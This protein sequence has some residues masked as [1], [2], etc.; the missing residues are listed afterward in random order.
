MNLYIFNET[1]KGAVY[2]IGTYIQELSTTLKSKDINICIINLNSNRAQVQIEEIK[3]IKYW[4]FPE[5]IKQTLGSK[6]QWDLYHRNIVYL[7][8]LGIPDKT[9]LIFHL[10]YNLK[11]EF[12]KELKKVFDCRIVLTVHYFDWCFKLFGN[13]TLLRQLLESEQDILNSHEIAEVKEIFQKERETFKLVDHIICLSEKTLQILINDYEIEQDKITVIYNGLANN[14]IIVKK[15]LLKQKFHIPDNS[16]ILLFVGRLDKIKGLDYALRAF[17]IVLDKYPECRLIIAG[18]GSFDC[19]LKECE[20]IWMNIIWTGLLK[21]EKL[22]E[23]YSIADIGIIPSFHEQCSYVAIEMM[24]H[25]LPIIGSTSTGLYEMIENNV[26]GLHIPVVEYSNRVEID[27]VVLA[28]KIIYLLDH[29]FVAK[30]M[31]QNGL[32]R[33]K[34]NYSSKIFRIH[35]LEMYKTIYKNRET[36]KIKTLLITGQNNHKWE[37][38]HLVIKQILENSELFTVDIAVSPQY[39]ENELKIKLDFTPYQLVV[40]DYN[41][42]RWSKE[43]D[44]SFL[45]FAKNGGGIVI[46]HASN[47]AFREWRDYN[48][49][50]GFG[51]WGNRDETD[52][53]YIY[54]K[55]GQL[56]YDKESKGCGGSHGIQHEFT[57]HCG[58]PNHPITNGLPAVWCHAKDELYDRMRGPGIIKDVLYSAYSDLETN[59]SGRDELV[60]FTVEYGEA[61]IFHTTLGH[62]GNTFDDNPAMQCTG[63]Q[64]TLLRGAEWAATGKVTQQVPTD[65]PTATNISFRKKYKQ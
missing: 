28:E 27:K 53:P 55:D 14:T 21:K 8:Q 63:F 41:G 54:L 16:P 1:R 42:D 30:R 32:K 22:Y 37:I 24:M 45:N 18:N 29:P 47:N 31:G 33:Y 65:F 59:G 7:L 48:R 46:Y 5:P 10:N 39:G 44:E 15:S 64:V 49:I 26:T 17:R 34:K 9:N 35:M 61:R 13:L 50:I 60:L 2:G 11:S 25:G 6:K 43:T 12:V 36:H 58:N 52:G 62:V 40:L 57:L 56:I 19:Y 4:Y 23:L 3:G 51:G 20:D 38:S